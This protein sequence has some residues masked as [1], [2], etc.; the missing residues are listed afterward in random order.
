MK[1][2]FKIGQELEGSGRSRPGF[3]KI[4]VRTDDSM[5]MRSRYSR[6]E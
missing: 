3:L 6:C 1:E 5:L 2:R 4:N